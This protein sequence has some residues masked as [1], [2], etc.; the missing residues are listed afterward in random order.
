MMK[1]SSGYSEA[2]MSAPRTQANHT[3]PRFLTVGQVASALSVSTDYVRRLLRDGF[4]SGI[5][6]P[7]QGKKT[8]IRIAKSSVDEFILSYTMTEI[9]TPEKPKKRKK[10]S[11]YEGLF[12][13]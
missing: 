6:M 3:L 8:P 7:G 11:R 13:K 2:F 9:V 1:E 4:L 12:T 10:R 5:K